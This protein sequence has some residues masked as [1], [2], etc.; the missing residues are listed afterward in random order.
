MTVLTPRERVNQALS[1]HNPDRMPVDFLA[2]PEV[3]KELIDHL[4]D[5][6]PDVEPS[7]YFDT[8][9]EALL[10][11]LDVDCRTVSYDQFVSAPEDK[12]QGRVDW[13]NALSR[14]TPNRMWRQVTKDGIWRTV[15][16]HNL[17]VFEHEQ[18][19]YEEV[20]APPLHAPADLDDLKKHSW[21]DPSWWDFSTLPDALSQLDRSTE[22]HIRFRIGSVFELAWQLRGMEQF[23]QDMV[24]EPEIP[25]YIMERIT[26]VHV[27]NTRRVMELASDRIDMVY[28]YDD[29]A[30]QNNLLMSKAMWAD[31][32]RPLHER[33]FSVAREY[34]KPI[35]YH[36]DGAVASLIP[37]W[38]EMGVK[39]LNPI[40]AD[41]P[42]MDPQFLKDTYGDRLSFHGGI[43]IIKTL[44]LGTEK[45]VRDEI[46]ERRRVLGDQGGYIMA[47]SHHIQ[48]G[49]PIENVLAMY[50][51]SLR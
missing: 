24:L 16:G 14:S 36:S 35:M 29:M 8:R 10:Q 15:W 2:T 30:A 34:D 17:Q 4:G 22:Y 6:L 46:S 39:V 19:A 33:I 5:A 31:Q 28:L 32:I 20:T 27:E 45:D 26:E 50:D 23:F 38:L 11:F 12:L 9:W 1:H 48:A 7:D 44:P 18:G 37:E 43:D 21:P 51:L 13:W 47:S 3:W 41:A 49:T 40:Q 42:G 25:A